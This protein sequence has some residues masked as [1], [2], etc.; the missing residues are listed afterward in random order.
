ML[1]YL[2]SLCIYM[3]SYERQISRLERSLYEYRISII[4]FEN[5]NLGRL[6]YET[7]QLIKRMQ[8]NVDLQHKRAKSLSDR[9]ESCLQSIDQ[10]E[11]HYAEARAKA[12]IV[13]SAL[14]ARAAGL[15]K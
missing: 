5:G 6:K 14:I 4:Y 11:K 7:S 10:L 3:P 1:L 15:I 12:T 8:K 13:R 9:C 2:I